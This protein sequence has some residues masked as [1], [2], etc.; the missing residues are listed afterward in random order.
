MSAAHNLLIIS[1]INR[2]VEINDSINRFPCTLCET[3]VFT[4]KSLKRHIGKKHLPGSSPD[5]LSLTL[6]EMGLLEP[7]DPSH[8]KRAEGN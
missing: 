3:V 7:P 5:N 1:R 8:Y 2:F 6:T 4:K